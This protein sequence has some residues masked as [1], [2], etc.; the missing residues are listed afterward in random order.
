MTIFT[1]I[2]NDHQAIKDLFNTLRHTSGRA[3]ESTFSRLRNLIEAHSRSE[4]D[5]LYRNLVQHRDARSLVLENY[6]EHHL[7]DLLLKELSQL[8]TQDDRWE[9]KLEVLR[10][11]LEAHIKEEEHSLFKRAKKRLHNEQTLKEMGQ[12]FRQLV[13][14]RLDHEVPSIHS[15]SDLPLNQIAAHSPVSQN[16]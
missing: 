2:K 7:V 8:S 9:P 12:Q 3:R 4:E 5:I 13:N 6:E 1:E 14:E 11:A 10:E 16:A 15:H